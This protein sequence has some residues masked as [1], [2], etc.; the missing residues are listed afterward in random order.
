MCDDLM[1]TFLPMGW[2]GL[3]GPLSWLALLLA[4]VVVLVVLVRRA[5]PGPGE[6]S[7]RLGAKAD[8][9]DAMRLLKARLASGGITEDEYHRLRR[10]IES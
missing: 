10:T 1:R 6:A 3:F 7:H 5:K 2:G 8:R 4:A 9:D